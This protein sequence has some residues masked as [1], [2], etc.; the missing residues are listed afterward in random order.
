MVKCLVK[1]NINQ[2]NWNCLFQH[3]N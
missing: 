3:G 2:P 1:N